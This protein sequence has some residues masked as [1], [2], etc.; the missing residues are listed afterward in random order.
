MCK[1]AAKTALLLSLFP[2]LLVT[3]S[4]GTGFLCGFLEGDYAYLSTYILF[5]LF[6]FKEMV[7]FCTKISVSWKSFPKDIQNYLNMFTA[8]YYYTA[9]MC[10]DLLVLL[11]VY[12]RVG[13][14]L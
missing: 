1:D 6:F 14:H 11:P 3:F 13:F 10:F 8:L 2:S 7:A 9:L 12:T 5:A 4:K